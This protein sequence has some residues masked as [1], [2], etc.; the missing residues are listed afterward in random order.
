MFVRRQ[1]SKYVQWYKPALVS[2]WSRLKDGY[3]KRIY[4]GIPVD[5]KIFCVDLFS[6]QRDMVKAEALFFI[7]VHYFFI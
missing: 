1:V 4:N 6:P 5:P 7:T 3:Y 2:P